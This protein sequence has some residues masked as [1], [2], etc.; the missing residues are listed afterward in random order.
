MKIMKGEVLQDDI[1]NYVLGSLHMP[2]A[3]RQQLE[4]MIILHYDV[5]D[6]KAKELVGKALV[7]ALEYYRHFES[8]QKYEL[9]TTQ[10]RIA[11][12]VKWTPELNSE[13]KNG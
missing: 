3:D 10:L 13:A 5:T 6:A 9:R 1:N 7:K 8:K 11:Q 12:L 2:V 4:A